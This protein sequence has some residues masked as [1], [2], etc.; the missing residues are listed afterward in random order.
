[1]QASY[2]CN[3][4]LGRRKLSSKGNLKWEKAALSCFLLQSIYCSVSVGIR[5]AL[6]EL[7][8]PV[9]AAV[10]LTVQRG[11]RACKLHSFWMKYD[12]KMH[13]R[14]APNVLLLLMGIRS[15]DQTRTSLKLILPETGTVGMLGPLHQLSSCWAAL[16]AN[17]DINLVFPGNWFQ[18]SF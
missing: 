4:M 16:P 2:S 7:H 18:N 8:H 1:M 3:L 9:L 15:M 5:N 10:W 17:A 14:N 13:S 11:F 12:W 6:W